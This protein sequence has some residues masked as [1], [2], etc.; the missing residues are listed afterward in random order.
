MKV[1]LT[2]LTENNLQN[3]D[4]TKKVQDNYIVEEIKSDMIF[5][6]KTDFD[7]LLR[8]AVNAEDKETGDITFNCGNTEYV[9]QAFIKHNEGTFN[10]RE[11]KAEKNIKLVNTLDCIINN[12]INIFDYTPGTAKTIQGTLERDEYSNVVNYYIGD[13]LMQTITLDYLISIVGNYPDRSA[14]GYFPEYIRYEAT[15]IFEIQNDPSYGD[16]E[17][18]Q[19]HEVN[20]FVVYVRIRDSIKHN[21]AWLPIPGEA[22]YF[23]SLLPS[24]TFGAPYIYAETEHNLG[25]TYTYYDKYLIEAGIYNQYKKTDISNT[26]FL[27]E[28]LEDIFICTGKQLVSNFFGINADATNPQNGAYD[29]ATLYCQNI[30]ICQSYDVIRENAQ[31]DSFDVS[32]LIKTKTL[33][34]NL[35]T[36]FNCRIIYDSEA[37]VIRFEHVTYY[38]RKGAN[39]VDAEIPYELKELKLNPDE[40]DSELFLFAQPSRNT[41]FYQAKISYNTPNLYQEENEKKYQSD[42][43]ITDVFAMLNNDYYEEDEAYKKLFFLFATDGTSIIGLNTPFAMLNIVKELHNILRP[44]K[45]GK[46][47]TETITFEGYSIGFSSEIKILNAS[48]VLWQRLFPFYSIILKE[49]TFL[50]D[51]ITFNNKEEMIVK[52]RK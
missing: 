32:G 43:F 6:E 22:D 3:Y 21:Y 7:Y 45:T 41:D 24:V 5:S 30:K 1:T 47:N 34:S 20:V 16:Y 39:F 2:N 29:F 8:A 50:I 14:E 44:L 27:N 33:L 35:L 42:L 18:Y 37:D 28:I 25:S 31:M 26:Y 13:Y 10:L 11:C 38:T 48:F 15:P 17:Q 51:E 52:I 23:Y 4:L 19:W 12:E 49:G 46:I 9:K 40:I 36:V